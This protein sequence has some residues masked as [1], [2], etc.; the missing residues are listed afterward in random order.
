MLISA[1]KRPPQFSLILKRPGA[2]SINSTWAETI[3]R[4]Q[5]YPSYVF[6]KVRISLPRK[7]LPTAGARLPVGK[8][9]TGPE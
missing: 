6:P 3:S 8:E 5:R 4:T 7:A 1:R 2:G 9:R